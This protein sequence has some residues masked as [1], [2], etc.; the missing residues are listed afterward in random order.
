LTQNLQLGKVR[1]LGLRPLA[2]KS[3]I[4][5]TALSLVLEMSVIKICRAK[6][7]AVGVV[8]MECSLRESSTAFVVI[9]YRRFFCLVG[10]LG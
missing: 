9:N 10:T 3:V 8:T 5:S 6:G 4:I 7:T 2:R 1:K